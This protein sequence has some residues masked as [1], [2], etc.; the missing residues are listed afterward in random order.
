MGNDLDYIRGVSSYFRSNQWRELLHLL[1]TLDQRSH[2]HLFV[3]T[4]LHPHTLEAIVKACLAA[5]N[6]PVSRGNE[7]LS[8]APGRGT[9]HGIH[10]GGT[11]HFDMNWHFKPDTVIEPME[12][13]NAEQGKN[14]LY[15]DELYMDYFYRNYEWR[16]LGSQETRAIVDYFDSAHWNRSFDLIRDPRIVHIHANVET[17]V[18]PRVL[19]RFT[20]EA[21]A[22]RGWKLHRVVP[23]V[24]RSQG[25]YYGKFMLLFEEPELSFDV[26]WIYNRDK[27][28]SPCDRQIFPEGDPGH[29][30]V[31][32]QSLDELIAQNNYRTLS[33]PEIAACLRGIDIH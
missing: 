30:I 8:P 18:H 27:V 3:N 21:V 25:T 10:P 17:S 16:P 33:L 6:L 20:I 13:A 19:E 9:L 31:F 26:S 5:E 1:R 29:M 32:N 15:W 23:N 2:I 11:A 14:I 28:L 7:I 12:E 22:R 4:S 24:F